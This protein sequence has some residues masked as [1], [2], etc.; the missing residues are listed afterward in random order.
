MRGAAEAKGLKDTP[1]HFYSH[2]SCEVRLAVA[3][4]RLPSAVIS[5]HTPHARC[6][7]S[8]HVSAS[9]SAD[10]YSHTSC[11]VRPCTNSTRWG[12]YKFLL[13]HLMRGA[14]SQSRYR[15]RH[16][17][18]LLTH[19]MRG[20]TIPCKNGTFVVDISTHTPHA[21]CD[22]PSQIHFFARNYFYSHTS[23][24]VRLL[25]V[26]F[27]ELLS[28]FYSHTSCEVRLLKIPLLYQFYIISTHTP[29]A[30]CD[31]I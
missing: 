27:S 17:T 30:R 21:R 9:L 20:A 8:S 7:I 29:H 10:F 31:N 14:T 12:A 26:P 15:Q 4:V 5:T 2:T 11:E 18:F 6:D 19:L 13:T 28:Y 3:P 24:E 25:T 1:T 22:A 16:R 23:C